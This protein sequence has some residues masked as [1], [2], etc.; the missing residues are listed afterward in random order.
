[1]S[2]RRVLAGA[3][4]AGLL[5]LVLVV[6]TGLGWWNGAAK[7]PAPA[8]LLSVRTVLDP[9]PAFF[10]DAVTAEVDVNADARSVAA[11]SINLQP[12]FDPFVET[13]P[14]V[15]T[16]RRAGDLLAVRVRYTIQC[17]SDSCVPLSKPLAVQLP[18]VP[19][20]AMSGSKTLK[21]S[22]AWAPTSIL[23]RLG[24]SDLSGKPHF[25]TGR[26]LPA[27]TYSVSPSVTSDALTAAAGVLALAGLALL[28]IEL[29]RLLERRR[30]RGIVRLTALEAALAYTRDAA[31]RP[32]PADRRKALGELTRVL[33]DEGAEPLAETAG[34]VAWSEQPPSPDRALEL[35]DE[36]ESARRNGG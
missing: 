22:A 17:S 6:G 19:V 13:G 26:T 29:V 14:P 3:A 15:T 16:T 10:G 21:V 32:D 11:R 23:S 2:D 5:V 28:G 12:T 8:Q 20:T 34:D 30:L 31:T 4:A 7:G 1:M 25:R 36:V 35:V 9:N 24:K 33:E 27:P 18:P